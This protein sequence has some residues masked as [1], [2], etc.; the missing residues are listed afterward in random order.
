MFQFQEILKHLHL[1]FSFANFYLSWR[2]EGESWC[3][4]QLEA[5]ISDN[6]E[7]GHNSGGIENFSS[8]ILMSVVEE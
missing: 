1:F 2:N 8:W 4:L 7:D 5:D 6:I 3:V